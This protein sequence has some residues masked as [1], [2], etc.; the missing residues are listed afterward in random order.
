[1]HLKP[2]KRSAKTNIFTVQKKITE[3]DSCHFSPCSGCRKKGLYRIR[4]ARA[5]QAEGHFWN[6][7]VFNSE[8]ANASQGENSSGHRLHRGHWSGYS[9]KA[10]Q[11]GTRFARPPALCTM[12]TAWLKKGSRTEGRQKSSVSMLRILPAVKPC[13]GRKAIWTSWSAILAL[14]ANR[15]HRSA[16]YVFFQSVCDSL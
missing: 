14:P 5:L 16:E 10:G 6:G 12:R 2:A 3:N 15:Q 7:T 8:S 11:R 13:A 9:E 4:C 1:M